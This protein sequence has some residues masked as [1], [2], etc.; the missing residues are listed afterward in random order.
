VAP[1]PL[2]VRSGPDGFRH[3]RYPSG[4]L[5]K[6]STNRDAARHA[7][8]ANFATGDSASRNLTQC[9][10]KDLHLLTGI[11]DPDDRDNPKAPSRYLT[12]G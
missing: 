10:T 8:T 4:L 2:A 9:R 11:S 3:D 7:L 6:W 12:F 1:W 5:I